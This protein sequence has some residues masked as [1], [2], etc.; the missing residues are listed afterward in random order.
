MARPY[1]LA[2]PAGPAAGQIGRDRLLA[3]LDARWSRRLTTIV[4]GPG[5]GKTTLLG[6]ALVRPHRD[7]VRDVWLSCEAADEDESY[8]LAGIASA[9]GADQVAHVDDLC[10]AI[11]LGAPTRTCFVLDDVH[12][13]PDDS[14]GMALLARLVT[15]LPGNA[16]LVLSSR[17][18]SS[19]WANLARLAASGQHCAL[20]ERELLF[21]DDELD[22]FAAIRGA[23]RAVLDES[24]GWPALAELL[25]ASTSEVAFEYVWDEVLVTLGEARAELLA[26]LAIVGGGDREVIAA[27]VGPD[28]DPVAL[29]AGVPLV[30]VRRDGWVVPHPLW[31]PVARRLLAPEA[32]RVA[33]LAAAGAHWSAGRLE[34]AV[35][36][37]T[38]AEAWDVLAALIR[39]VA[40]TKGVL[41]DWQRV[42]VW[43]RRLPPSLRSGSAGLLA[44]GMARASRSPLDATQPFEAAAALFRAEGDAAGEVA[45]IE[46]LGVVRWWANDVAGV[47]ALYQRAVELAES[48][49][50]EAA[51]LTRV[52]TAAIAHLTGDPAGVIAALEPLGTADSLVW[53]PGIWWFRHVAYRRLG[54]VARAEMALDALLRAPGEI[55][56]RQNAVA[57]LRTDW[58]LGRVDDGAD[59]MLA[60]AE[61]YA[62]GEHGYLRTETALEAAARYAWLGDRSAARRILD[63]VGPQ[64]G[65][66]PGPVVRI[67]HAIALAAAAVDAGDEDAARRALVDS[68]LARP[69]LAER[70]YWWDRAAVALPHQL[71]VEDRVAWMAATPSPWHRLGSELSDLL[72]SARAGDLGAFADFAWPSPGRLRANLPARWV[73]E[74]VDAAEAAGSPAP[75]EVVAAL[76]ARSARP[77]RR[78][79][80]KTSSRGRSKDARSAIKLLVLGPMAL[81]NGDGAVDHPDLQRIRVRQ[82]LA[83]LALEPVQRRETLADT[84]WPDHPDPRQNLRV[85][86]RY[87]R[88]LLEIASADNPGGAALRTD[89]S[90][91]RLVPGPAMQCDL[92]DFERL[93][94]QAERAEAEG[95]PERALARYGEAIALW[96]GPVFADLVEAEHLAA[97]R[98]RLTA[99]LLGVVARA[100]DLWLAGDRPEE[101]LRA[102]SS[103]TLIDPYDEAARCLV[104]RAHLARGDIRCAGD[105]LVRCVEMLR[106]LGVTPSPATQR[107]IVDMDPAA[108]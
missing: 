23:D 67:H 87:V 101:A 108:R 99:R 13:L 106:E 104:V 25:V 45:A 84:I 24:G 77:S 9:A 41:E 89:R 12:E 71:L 18:K 91:V 20:T 21:D 59:R 27:T 63:D 62:S 3:V 35:E 40:V 30:D 97:P 83:S 94:D 80:P 42:G 53:G 82:L 58:L 68:E 102:A 107:L 64:L 5:F 55:G 105:E 65:A 48:G 88:R 26:K 73:Q 31:E 79:A 6:A 103:A 36:L 8:L 34:R 85:T 7:D 38:D 60:I 74:L 69:D 81:T 17:V 50:P 2:P 4:A 96:R 49:V 66:A 78:P 33:R 51:V 46:R 32:A 11:W 54:D 57:R 16:S 86:L 95:E 28:V 1:R 10:R 22:R 93:L 61:S 98:R 37:L 47:W 43:G 29:V 76:P 90:V 15:E 52:G 44:E 75:F 19:G 56:P 70:W 100:G 92:W 72:S 14:S 39:D